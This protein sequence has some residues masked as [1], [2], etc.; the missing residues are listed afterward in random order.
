MDKISYTAIPVL[1]PKT[2]IKWDPIRQ[3]HMLLF[4]EGLLVLNQTAQEIIIMC[5]GKHKV[6]DIVKLLSD[7]YQL[8][9]ET[10]VLDMLS[11]LVEKHLLLIE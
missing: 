7:K 9:V 6:L 10:D 1:S 4:P 8:C 2:R 5:D 11:R 3:K